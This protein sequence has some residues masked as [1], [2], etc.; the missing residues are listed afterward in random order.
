MLKMKYFNDWNWGRRRLVR[1][2][3]V[4][5]YVVVG[6]TKEGLENEL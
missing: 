6:D 2:L 1:A 5:F 4:K 3:R